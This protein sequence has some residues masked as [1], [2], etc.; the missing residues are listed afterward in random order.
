MSWQK[1]QQKEQNDNENTA[2]QNAIWNVITEVLRG[3]FIALN[4]CM[5]NEESFQISNLSFYIK[6]LDKEDQIKSKAWAEVR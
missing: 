2:Y 3:E 5:R 4:A 1:Q 6:K